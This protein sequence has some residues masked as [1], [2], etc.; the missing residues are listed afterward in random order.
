MNKKEKRGLSPVIATILLVSLAL[1]LAVIV[2]LWAKAFMPEAL[3]KEGSAIETS[4]EQVRFNAEAYKAD[5]EISVENTGQIPIYGIEIRK[6]QFIG[7]VN[8]AEP[9]DSNILSGQSQSIPLPPGIEGGDT[10]VLIPI[11][12]GVNDKGEHKS[13]P[14]GTD[15]GMEIEVSS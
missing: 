12:V 10:L 11:L 8:Q 15:Y 1:V 6:K 13:Y 2:Y 5:Q 7:E 14:C 9:F 3:Q 4:C